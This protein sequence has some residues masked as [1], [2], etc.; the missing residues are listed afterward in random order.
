MGVFEECAERECSVT[1][2]VCVT[3]GIVEGAVPGELPQS[4]VPK[5]PSKAEI[6][7]VLRDVR[8]QVYGQSNTA[9]D[10]LEWLIRRYA[11]TTPDDSPGGAS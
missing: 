7:R 5:A 10:V 4:T 9:D 1:G 6:H 2:K 8:G 11:P 3:Y